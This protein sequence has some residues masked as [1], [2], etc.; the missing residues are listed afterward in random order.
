GG[1]PEPDDLWQ[2]AD[3]D[4]LGQGHPHFAFGAHYAFLFAARLLC[5]PVRAALT[6]LPVRVRRLLCFPF[7][8][9]AHCACCSHRA[10]TVLPVGA[11]RSLCFPVR[12]ARSLFSRSPGAHSGSSRSV[13]AR[14]AVMTMSL[15]TDAWPVTE[16]SAPTRMPIWALKTTWSPGTTGL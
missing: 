13:T 8:F 7:A 3:P 12:A 1:A 5:F 10:L 6:V 2:R 9:G 14:R 11:A 4:H 16:T 15:P